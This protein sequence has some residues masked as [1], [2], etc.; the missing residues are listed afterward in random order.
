MAPVLK[1][2]TVLEKRGRVAKPS[3]ERDSWAI[4][5]DQVMARK[6]HELATKPVAPVRQTTYKERDVEFAEDEGKTP[7]QWPPNQKIEEVSKRLLKIKQMGIRSEASGD[8]FNSGDLAYQMQE[9]IRA[10]GELFQKIQRI[11]LAQR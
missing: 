7:I 5:P 2:P 8:Y 11:K 4:D 10:T 1:M 6:I 3:S 9:I